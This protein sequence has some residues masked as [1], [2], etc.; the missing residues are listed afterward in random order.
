MQKGLL[1]V[2]SSPSGGGKTT[3]IR[4]L[5]EAEPRIR[6]SVSLTTRAPRPGEVHG[7]DYL[8]VSPAEFDR[9]KQSGDLL[10]WAQ[11]HGHFY[12]TPRSETQEALL[13]GLDVVL[14]I[15]VQGGKQIKELYPEALLIFIAPPNLEALK[16]RLDQRKQD[17]PETIQQRLL[18]ATSE[19]A[20]SREYD[21]II[22]NDDLEKAFADLRMVVRA[23][24]CR[25]GRN[26]RLIE[27]F[28]Q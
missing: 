23:E 22:V 19:I 15:D 12:G 14:D 27:S 13:Q 18:A 28:I 9:R 11:V 4:K 8:F 16:I 5:R 6:Y 24:K 1:I 25:T 2:I 21:F 3:L 10:E 20:A 17:A 26:I 7:K